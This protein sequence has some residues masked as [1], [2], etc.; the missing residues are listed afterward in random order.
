MSDNN[1]GKTRNSIIDLLRIVLTVLVVNVHIRIITGIKTNFLEPYTWY[2]V[3]L[4][5]VISFFFFSSKP[6]TVR[7]KRL[8]IPFIFWSTAG[9]IIHSNLLNA[10]NVL[11][12][13][14]TGHVVD[15]PLYYLMLL[16]W[17]TI[18]Y[19]LINRLPSNTRIFIYFL[20]ILATLFLEYSHINYDFFL[21]QIEVIKKSYGRF[22]ELI[23][24]VPIGLMFAFLNKK[25]NNNNVYLI[26]SIIF[27]PVY[28]VVSYLP[29][30]L[31]FHYSGLKTL[32]GTII[33]FSLVL[34]LS[35][36]K[37]NNKVNNFIGLLGRYSFGVYLLHYLLLESLLIINPALKSSIAIYQI[38][39]LFFYMASCY[40]FCLLFDFLT[41]KKLSFLIQ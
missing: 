28:V 15:T 8:F 33:I 26:I 24:Y 19:W 13:L 40:L 18:I 37:F 30:P 27:L 3:P 36:F 7:I 2:T 25:I 38:P 41:K 9:F 20:I 32:V 17:F 14:I 12:Q 34:G 4:F 10:K 21:P 29:Q 39:F 6:L 11:L 1:P 35:D 31:D 23:K 22:I 16:C 5:I